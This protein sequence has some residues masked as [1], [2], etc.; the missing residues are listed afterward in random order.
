LTD[1]N[2]LHRTRIASFRYDTAVAVAGALITVADLFTTIAASRSDGSASPRRQIAQVALNSFG[3]SPACLEP[4]NRPERAG[5]NT[6]G[7]PNWDSVS[8]AVME[9]RRGGSR[10]PAAGDTE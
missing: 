4:N 1:H 10:C 6:A 8:A 7:S 9:A 5:D 3:R 2:G